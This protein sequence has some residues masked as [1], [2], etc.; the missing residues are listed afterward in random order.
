[1][2]LAQAEGNG[3]FDAQVMSVELVRPTV[4]ERLHAAAVKQRAETKWLQDAGYGF[5]MH[6]TAH[7]LADLLKRFAEC[8]NVPIVN[9]EIYQ[10]GT[11]S[12]ATIELFKQASATGQMLNGDR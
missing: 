8:K 7:Q 3:D 9:L 5:M 6:W 12:P 4:R 1:M 11:L 10:D 2:K